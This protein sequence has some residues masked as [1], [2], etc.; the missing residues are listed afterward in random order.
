M[1][2]KTSKSLASLQESCDYDDKEEFAE[3][4]RPPCGSSLIDGHPS[5]FAA[6][7]KAAQRILRCGSSH[8]EELHQLI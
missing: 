4:T 5:A 1:K 2:T 8:G 3:N 6:R 7:M